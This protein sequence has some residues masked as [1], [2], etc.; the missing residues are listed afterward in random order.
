MEPIQLLSP[1]GELTKRDDVPIDVTAELCRDFYRRMTLAR[2]LD[3]QALNLQRQGELGLWLQCWGQEAAQVGSVTAIRPEDWVFPSYR[4]HAAALC[5]GITPAELLSQWRGCAASG[6]DP[7]RYRFGVYTLVLAAQLLH[8]TGFAMGV[9]R[10]GADEIVLT[11]FGDGASSEGDAS[12]SFNW[13]ATTQAP[14]L[15]FCQNNQWAISTPSAAQTRTA[16]HERAAGFGLTSYLVDGNDVLA[17]HAITRL[18]AVGI[19]AGNGPAFVE[20]RTYRMGGHST[21]DDPR[22]YRTAEELEQWRALDP[23]NR[24]RLLLDRR[25]WADGPFYDALAQEADDLAADVRRT[26]LRLQPPALAELFDEVLAGPSA[27]L[28]E[29]RGEY[30]AYLSGFVTEDATA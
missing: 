20:A 9:L 12:E 4:D 19:R 29:E 3:T 24:L 7:Y 26:C 15:F 21:S 17:V 13:A 30:L 23:I 28:A 10:D 1:D 5:R 27:P 14:V 11:Y 16:L 8:A 2:L 6:W 18:A 22:R 25:D